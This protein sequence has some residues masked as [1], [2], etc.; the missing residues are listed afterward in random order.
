MSEDIIE[1]NQEQNDFN[2]KSND[3]EEQKPIENQVAEGGRGWLVIIGTGIG[4]MMGYG[5]INSFGTYQTYYKNELYPE[6]SSQ[7]LSLIGAAQSTFIYI[8][9]PI[10]MPLMY[11]VGLRTLLTCGCALMIV[12]F[13]GLSTATSDSRWKIYVFQAVIYSLGHS[14]V[15]GSII[16]SPMEWFNKRRATAYSI[17]FVFSCT[18]GV[19][20]P[21]IFKNMINKHGFKWTNMTIG[22]LYIPL[23]IAVIFLIP[24]R[25]KP[26]HIHK[27]ETISNAQFD[28]HKFKELPSRIMSNIRSWKPVLRDWRFLMFLLSNIIGGFGIFPAIFFMD[29]YGELIAPGAKIVSY[30]VMMYNAVGAPGRVIPGMLADKIGRANVLFIWL[31]VC[32]LSIFVFWMTSIPGEDMNLYLAY[33][34]FFGFFVGPYFS[35]A[36]AC[37]GQVFSHI[38]D[39]DAKLGLYLLS[40]SPGPLVGCVIAGSFVPTESGDKELLLDS[41]YKLTAFTG[42]M[43]IAGSLVVLLVRLSFTRKIFTYI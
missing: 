24:Q 3:Y 4:A 36:P 23:S 12:S 18:G 29:Y 8:L 6:T 17:S 26:E 28:I 21:L 1:K 32:G 42:S 7:S 31:F 40:L 27:P 25:L 2:T 43:I 39:A 34:I 38:E 20:F 16:Q 14:L 30:L 5:M 15:F 35:L 11:V 9:N 13:F 37:L 10:I 22:F 41:F 33:T 19:I